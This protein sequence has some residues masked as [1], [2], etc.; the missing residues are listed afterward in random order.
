MNAPITPLELAKMAE[1]EII[2]ATEKVAIEKRQVEQLLKGRRAMRHNDP[3]KQRLTITTIKLNS[4]G[5]IQLFGK[6]RPESNTEHLL[7]GLAAV[8]ILP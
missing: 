1:K 3:H 8:E 5:I 2:A 6:K 7:G 4:L